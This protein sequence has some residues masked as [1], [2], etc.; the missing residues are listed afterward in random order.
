[1]SSKL[2][3]KHLMSTAGMFFLALS[4]HAALPGDSGDGKRL[5]DANCTGC[6][7]AG[8]YTRQDHAVRSL[9]ALKQQLAGCGHMAKKQFSAAETENIVKYLNDRYYHFE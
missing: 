8:V 2:K 3:M 7:D 6:H 4:A 1:M 9:D 5:H